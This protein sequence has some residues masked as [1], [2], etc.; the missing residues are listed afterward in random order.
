MI[1]YLGGGTV[2][3]AVLAMNGIVTAETSRPGGLKLDDAIIA[4]VRRKFGVINGQPTAEQLKIRIG[5]GGNAGAPTV[6][7]VQGQAQ[8]SGHPK[9]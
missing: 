3:A 1:L 9:R 6:M 5:N 8:V 7:E 2:Q 4:Y